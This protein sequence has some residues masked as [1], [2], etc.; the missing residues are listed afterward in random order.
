MRVAGTPGLGVRS[1]Q[2]WT[3]REGTA[4]AAWDVFHTESGQVVVHGC[5]S[6]QESMKAA[7]R[8]ADGIDW[9]RPVEALVEDGEAR[10]RMHNVQRWVDTQPK[11]RAEAS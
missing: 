11:R 6:L 8:L 2:A 7:K 1:G 4:H 10:A 5:R 9:T 3:D